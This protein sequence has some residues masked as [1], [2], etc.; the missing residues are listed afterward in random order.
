MSFTTFKQQMNNYM[1]NQDGIG[2]FGDF[3]KKITQEY[4]LAIKRGFQTVNS[5]PISAG[6][7]AGMENLVNIACTVAL[8]KTGGLH[9][10]GDD[11]GKGVVMYWTGATLITG[12]PPVIPATGAIQNVTTTAAVCMIPGSWTPMGPLNPIDDSNIFLGRLVASMMSHL[13]TTQFMYNTLSIYP[14]APPP[15][16]PGVLISPG[17]TVP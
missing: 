12:I 16:A 11:I 15:V 14:G 4:D 5:I 17:Y 3:A 8:S 1:T 6:N 7:T 13:P 2:S 10:F 9:T